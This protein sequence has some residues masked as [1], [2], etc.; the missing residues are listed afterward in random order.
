MSPTRTIYAY[1]A[2]AL[3]L[4]ACSGGDGNPA[5]LGEDGYTS[6]IHDT[7]DT[8]PHDDDAGTVVSVAPTPVPVDACEEE[9]A[10]STCMAPVGTNAGF[11]L[12][13]PGT[14]TCS[15]GRW[16]LCATHA[17]S[18]P[19]SGWEPVSVGCN[20][21]PESCAAEGETRACVK[22]LPPTPEQA[23]NCYHGKQFCIDRAWGPCLPF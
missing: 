18:G 17:T 8:G 13:A 21:A 15:Q 9:G 6:P 5:P 19:V 10:I 12:C 16:T 11:V 7:A 1:A 2:V 22:Q 3:S 20:A 14:R 23:A 4:W